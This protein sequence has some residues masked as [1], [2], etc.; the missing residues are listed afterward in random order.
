VDSEGQMLAHRPGRPGQ[1]LPC[2]PWRDWFHGRGDRQG[3]A[4]PFRPVRR[5]HI[6]QPYVDDM[7]SALA[8]AISVPIFAADDPHRVGEPLALLVAR[9]PITDLGQWVGG[10]NLERG[11]LVLLNDRYHCLVH[12]EA[13]KILPRQGRTPRDYSSTPI[14][15]EIL[16]QGRS[17]TGIHRDPIDDREYLVSY[18]AFSQGTGQNCR[19]GALVQHEPEAVRVPV[20]GLRSQMRLIGLL[21]LGGSAT[22]L[23]VLWAWLIVTLR[24]EEMP[25]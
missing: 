17:G 19:W 3:E 20:E 4:G 8:V 10:V 6:S 22:L 18:A 21:T 24:R 15:R 14:Y 5:T 9:F 25:V 2:L 23:T 1:P 13:E 11:F 7:P 12:R 16:Q